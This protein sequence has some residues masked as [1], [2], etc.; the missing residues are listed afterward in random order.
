MKVNVTDR[1]VH[2][3]CQQAASICMSREF[4]QLH[5]EMSK[6]YRKKGISDAPIVAFQDSLFSL[7]MEQN[8]GELSS[9]SQFL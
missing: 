6:I 4:K 5:K 1:Q 3:F 7:F 9:Q 8:D 2:Y